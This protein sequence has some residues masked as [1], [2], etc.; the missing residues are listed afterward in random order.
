MSVGLCFLLLVL[1]EH[2]GGWIAIFSAWMKLKAAAA[3][4]KLQEGERGGDK[5][6]RNAHVPLAVLYFF[7]IFFSFSASRSAAS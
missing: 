6:A 4:K 2:V 5:G 7:S 1:R 3:T